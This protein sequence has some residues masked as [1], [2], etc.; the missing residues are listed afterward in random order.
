M[1][2]DSSCVFLPRAGLPY[3]A[4]CARTADRASTCALR[5]HAHAHIC[6]RTLLNPG[7]L[8]NPPASSSVSCALPSIPLFAPPNAATSPRALCANDQAVRTEVDRA[9]RNIAKVHGEFT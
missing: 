2:I 7:V 4:T 1:S 9:M 8:L 5:K 3:V 6:A